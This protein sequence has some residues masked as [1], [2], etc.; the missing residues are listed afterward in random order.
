MSPPSQCQDLPGPRSAE[1]RRASP[2]PSTLHSSVLDR[3]YRLFTSLKLTVALLALGLVLVF[4]GTLAQVHLGLYKA[5]NDFFRSFFVYWEPAG[6]RLRLPIFP[7]GYL[8]GGLLLINLVA[9][10]TRYYQPGKRKIGI[11]LIHA[12]VVLLLLGQL[13]TDM[14]STESSMHLRNG[15]TKNYSESDRRFELALLDKTDPAADRVTALS[16]SLL[17]KGGEVRAAGLP[18]AIRVKAYFP[19]SALAEK[20]APG[21]EQVRT[22]GGVGSGIWWRE[23]PRETALERRDT[24][25]GLLELTAPQGSLGTFLVSGFLSRPQEFSR[26]GRR[27][28]MSLRPLRY[29]KTFSLHLVEFRHDKYPGTDIPKNFSSRVRLQEPRTGEDR[30]VLIRMNTPLRYRGE[31]FYQA[32]FDPD[33]QGSVLQVVRN[34]SWLT[35]YFSC[36]LVAAGLVVQFSAHLSRFAAK[37]RTA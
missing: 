14:L 23:M 34:P 7:G 2:G 6:F 37:R 5:Q 8:V 1:E 16:E 10:H 12:G 30:E 11:M 13:L 17:L 21:F 35:P 9:A 36:V 27:Y 25:S 33:D 22:T 24:P 26:N 20:P 4:W 3:L 28:E 15:E 32:S 29:Y 31:T 18:F 19:N